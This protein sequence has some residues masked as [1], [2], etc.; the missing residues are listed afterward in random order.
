M[1]MSLY[2][3][4][5][6]Y[7]ILQPAQWVGLENFSRLFKDKMV[8]KALA[9]TFVYTM[10]TVPLQTILS[11]LCASVLAEHF[12]GRFGGFVKSA[13]FIPVIAST[14]L[15]GTL[16]SIILSGTGVL[17]STLKLLGGSSVFW[18]AKPNTAMLSVGMASVWKNTGYFL[19]IFYAGLMDVPRSL[20]EAA[21][22]DGASI[23]QR[24]FHITL[25]SLAPVTYLVVTLGT[26][27]S[28][29][30]FDMVYTMT[31][32]GPGGSTTTLVM[33]IYNTAFKEYSMGY[34]SAIA[35]LAFCFVMLISGLQK[36]LLK[37]GKEEGQ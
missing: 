14:V 9:N 32:G 10:M 8:W 30:V 2:F 29:Q 20:Y 15:V 23:P 27:W 35:M 28:F 18:L 22:V 33:L 3:C 36:R 24:F 26:I 13:M 31:G 16:W 37:G 19:V 34:A 1:G 25:P 5:T 21:E 7:N 11:L 6:K 17:N 12:R 4:F